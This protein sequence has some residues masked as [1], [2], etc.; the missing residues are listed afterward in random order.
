MTVVLN[1]GGGTQ[2]IATCI[3]VVRG[4]LPRPEF[5]IAA[6]TG[7]EVRST[8]E[9]M[10]AHARPLLAQVGLDVEVAPHDLATVDLY[11]HNGTLLLPV[12]TPTGKFS[13]Y[14]SNEWKAYVVDRYLR[15]R[16][17]KRETHW[18]GF[19]ADERRRVKPEKPGPCQRAYPLLD[20]ML[21]RSDC[22]RIILDAGLPLP[23]K[24]AC[25]MCP[26]RSNVEWRAV[27]DQCPDQ[28][29][30][31]IRIDEEIRDA[32]ELGAVYLHQSRVP[33]AEADLDAPDRKVPTRQCGLGACFV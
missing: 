11:G 26:H 16:G 2:T 25:L 5:V 15:A 3:L 13:T 29:A 6:D 20:L 4:I 12:F 17:I 7:R 8:W 18:I 21:T 23:E 27:R 1:Y 22:E 10:E 24:S 33:L 31:A 9:Y 32:D 28:W 30:E 14:C 19:S